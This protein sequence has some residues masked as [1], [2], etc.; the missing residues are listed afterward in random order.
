MSLRTSGTLFVLAIGLMEPTPSAQLLLRPGPPSNLATSPVACPGTFTL[1][2]TA[3]TTGDA[4]ATYVIEAGFAPGATSVTIPTGS[5]TPFYTVRGAPVGIYYVRVRAQNAAG[6]SEPSNEI[7]L[8]VGPCPCFP[9][10]RPATASA[11]VNGLLV[12]L[13]WDESLGADSYIIEAGSTPGGTDLARFDTGSLATTF[14]ASVPPGTYYIRIRGRNGCGESPPSPEIVVTVLGSAPALCPNPGPLTGR[15]VVRAAPPV[16]VS[17]SGERCTPSLDSS[18]NF[19][20]RCDPLTSQDPIDELFSGFVCHQGN[21]LSIQAQQGP[22]QVT[23][24][25]TVEPLGGTGVLDDRVVFSFIANTT[26]DLGQGCGSM[27]VISVSSQ[28]GVVVAPGVIEG[29]VL[30]TNA[31]DGGCA[32]VACTSTRVRCEG[33]GRYRIAISPGG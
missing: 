5:A 28:N 23:F 13:R 19:S 21:R 3:P 2:W 7:A 27:Q 31:L 26:V 32:L 8:G 10:T 30:F 29:D 25:G 1:T 14:S 33:R 9:P 12:T 17:C 20:C 22:T 15:W 11:S 16:I 4:P 6:I 24:S 18:G